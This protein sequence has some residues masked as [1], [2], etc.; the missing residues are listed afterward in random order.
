MTAL[1]FPVTVDPAS[2][3]AGPGTSA[4]VVQWETYFRPQDIPIPDGFEDIDALVAEREANP[5]E[6]I[7]LEAARMR[8]AEKLKDIHSGLATLRLQQGWSQKQLAQAIGTSQSHIARIENGR[9]NVLLE[10]ANKLARALGVTLTEI[11]DALG[12]SQS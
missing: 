7:A 8:L 6:R 11:N 3:P 1:A 12:Y 9:D 4:D 10:T 5:V 2:V